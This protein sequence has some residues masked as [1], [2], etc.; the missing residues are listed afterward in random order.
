MPKKGAGKAAA[1]KRKSAAVE[2]SGSDNNININE[3]VSKRKKG[4]TS[5]TLF[6]KYKESGE[7]RIGPDG[8]EALF[9]DMEVSPDSVTALILAWKL[10]AE[11]MGYF[12]RE[13]F[14]VNLDKFGVSDITSLR[15][16][17][18]QIEKE[19]MANAALFTDLYKYAFTFCCDK[20]NKK[21][22]DME[23]AATMIELILP[24]GPHTQKF[25]E[26][27]KQTKS[28]KVI[29]KDQWLCFLE[30]SR[31]VKGDLS[32]YDDNEAWPLLIDEYVEFVRG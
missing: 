8:M 17:V 30:F 13:E 1:A 10:K 12:K 24:K 26:F 7:D 4:D 28:Y 25:L 5:I 18:L 3:P 19:T 9:K 31:N 21:S 22:V 11:E 14:V 2:K 29:N 6:E 27:L 20:N 32:N 15:K 23:T 16:T